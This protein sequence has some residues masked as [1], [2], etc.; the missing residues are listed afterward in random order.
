MKLKITN[1]I[2]AMQQYASQL[3]N[4]AR[5]SL[6]KKRRKTNSG[7]II[8]EEDY[9]HQNVLGFV[10]SYGTNDE[11]GATGGAGDAFESSQEPK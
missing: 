10:N 7:T 1:P 5:E 4:H 3:R 11:Q 6:I 2:P 8:V 9:M